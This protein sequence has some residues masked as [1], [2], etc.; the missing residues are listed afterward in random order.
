MANAPI[1]TVMIPAFN[2]GAYIGVAISSCQRQTLGD[3]EIL[4]VDDGSTDDTA[5]VVQRYTDDSRVRLISLGANRGVAAARNTALF[6]ATG[7]WIATLDAD[8]WMTD[9]RLEVLVDAAVAANADL[10]HDDLPLIYEGETEPYSTLARS[11]GSVITTVT[12]VNLDRLIDCEVGGRSAYRLGLTQPI[13]RR[14][15]LEA[16]GIRYDER[17]KVGEDYLLYLECLL[18]GATWIQIPSGHYFYLQRPASASRTRQ[19]PTLERKLDVCVEVLERPMLTPAQRVS[20]QRYHRNLSSILAYQRVVEPAKERQL[21]AAASAAIRNP[22]FIGRLAKE[23]PAVARRR[24]AY[25]ARRDS[26]A[27]DMLR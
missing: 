15:F 16:H 22:R 12:A 1:V 14:A 2:A 18:A 19:V 27:L 10:A 26:H 8:D 13:L 11:T 7:T 23:L 21:G 17:L 9:D 3:I 25:H 20:L 24:W 6:H 4:V 5:S